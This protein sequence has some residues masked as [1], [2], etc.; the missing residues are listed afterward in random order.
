MSA[1]L[2]FKIDNLI[3]GEI[4]KRPSK[5][6][7]TPY[8]ADIIPINDNT[9]R[10]PNEILGHTASLGCCGLSDTGAKIL[11]APIAVKKNIK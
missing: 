4:I 9:N 10:L 11:M 2:L 3:E 5:Y 1:N 7:K 8:V 6:I